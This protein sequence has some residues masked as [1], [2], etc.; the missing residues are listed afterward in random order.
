MTTALA[1]P[2]PFSV[3]T[4]AERGARTSAWRELFDWPELGHAH[5]ELWSD[6]AQA[7]NASAGRLDDAILQ[8]DKPVLL[9]AEGAACFAA[10]WWAR[11]S[12][13]SYVERVAGALLFRPMVTGGDP[14]EAF[15][16]PRV[17]LPFPTLLVDERIALDDAHAL[18]GDW[19]SGLTDSRDVQ[20]GRGQASPWRHAQRM[21]E[22]YTVSV[23]KRDIRETRVRLR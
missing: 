19:G 18:A 9:L 22:R 15:A 17:R 20:R 4:I 11:L 14:R 10:V 13:T 21:I 8:S 12:P 1:M 16:S 5:V 6:T 2:G 3:V 23:V 7:R